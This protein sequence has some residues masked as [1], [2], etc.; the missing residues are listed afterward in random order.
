MLCFKQT[1]ISFLLLLLSIFVFLFSSLKNN[2][3]KH[4]ASSLDNK[5]AN[6]NNNKN[7]EP[8]FLNDEKDANEKPVQN[9]DKNNNSN[10]ILTD[11][12]PVHPYEGSSYKVFEDNIASFD[13]N[14]LE[15][16]DVNLQ[17]SRLSHHIALESKLNNIKINN[18]AT[19][20]DKLRKSV[21]DTNRTNQNNSD[22]TELETNKI[23][24]NS[25]QASYN[26][27]EKLT[28]SV[29]KKTINLKQNFNS[30]LLNNSSSVI[31]IN[32]N[33]NQ[34]D[35]TNFNSKTNRHSSSKK[36]NS[37][38]QFLYITNF[39]NNHSNSGNSN[40]E[41][42]NVKRNTIT[43]NIDL[44][45]PYAKSNDQGSRKSS[46]SNNKV[47]NLAVDDSRAQKKIPIKL[48]I[49]SGNKNKKF[50]KSSSLNNSDR[51]NNMNSNSV[52]NSNNKNNISYNSNINQD[53][54]NTV[55]INLMTSNFQNFKESLN[56]EKPV[57]N[58]KELVIDLTSNK[59]SDHKVFEFEV[60][61]EA[62]SNEGNI[63]QNSNIKKSK[64]N[65][66][67]NSYTNCS[68]NIGN[69]NV[70]T[71][72]GSRA[73][74]IKLQTSIILDSIRLNNSNEK[75]KKNI[76][77]EKNSNLKN[78][79]VFPKTDVLNINNNINNT[80]TDSNSNLNP[81]SDKNIKFAGLVNSPDL[82][83]PKHNSNNS[84]DTEFMSITATEDYLE[85]INL[86]NNTENN[87]LN[88]KQVRNLHVN[89]INPNSSKEINDS[90]KG[91]SHK[92]MIKKIQINNM[93]PTNNTSINSENINNDDVAKIQCIG[94]DSIVNDNTCRSIFRH[95][96]ASL[97]NPLSS[98]I[99]CIGGKSDIITRKLSIETN[100][101]TVIREI[102]VERSDFLALMYKEKRI[103]IMGGKCLN[104]NGVESV[105]DT[106][107]LLSTDEQNL[108]RLDFKLKIPRSNFGAVYFQY[109]LYVAG[110]YN[111]RDA[112]NNFE[113]FDKKSKKW[114]D[115]PRMFHK[116]KEFSMI[117]G[118][119]NNIYSLG[120]SDE[121]E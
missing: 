116:K 16:S 96:F 24:R 76:E 95:D 23:I 3:D 83:I 66:N 84:K 61:N 70:I 119:D 86:P 121:R 58:K 62:R 77:Q 114:I 64:L 104:Y 30:K 109:K 88:Q 65:E 44:Q 52:L 9:F 18:F 59:N 113:Y 79:I 115:L 28:N 45:I 35:E 53:Q 50:I 110:G 38:R 117:L 100:A 54:N 73:E 7:Y 49:S 90:H 67:S 81:S 6:Q 21:V 2:L 107:D 68:G 31:E 26:K 47:C 99:L 85:L 10:H 103:L 43:S 105:S 32:Y 37:D 13:S 1:I 118:P 40:V 17:Q 15:G 60:H 74:K 4:K 75:K 82:I 56:S 11:I 34:T 51:K 97:Y 5:P 42:N 72:R 14:I 92:E 22:K 57:K 20:N 89:A 41:T 94:L 36:T 101:W 108:V 111:G 98:H 55:N 93:N 63:L 120:G 8:T 78:D 33:Q 106:I 25:P 19:T 48:P 112:L 29:Y 27:T 80:K 91:I 71:I 87:K 69:K 39:N 12:S 46:S 102:K